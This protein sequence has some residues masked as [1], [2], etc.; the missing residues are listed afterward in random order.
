V[1]HPI[2]SVASTIR[3]EVGNHLREQV[4]QSLNMRIEWP[5]H[6]LTQMFR[7]HRIA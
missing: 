2:S 3:Y 4:D 1:H 5:F 6:L 7:L